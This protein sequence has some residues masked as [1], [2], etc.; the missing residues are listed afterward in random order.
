MERIIVESV[1]KL[2]REDY[3]EAQRAAALG[4]IFGVDNQLVRDG[5]YLV[6]E[7][8]SESGCELVACGAWS[9]RANKFGSDAVPGKN[10]AQLDPAVDPAR[11]RGFFVHPGWARQG[12]ATRILQECEEAARSAGFGSAELVATVTGEALYAVHGYSV[13]K[14]FEI[15]LPNGVMLPVIGMLKAL[16]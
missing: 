14:R 10:D 4:L 1:Q 2:Q 11:I 15:P 7:A 9:K 13:T 12:I 6:A 3:T 16:R 8:V 5:T